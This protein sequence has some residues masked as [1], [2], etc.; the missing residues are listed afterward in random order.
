MIN[1]MDGMNGPMR[2]ME[3]LN[4]LMD[5]LALLRHLKLLPILA[6]ALRDPSLESTVSGPLAA[7]CLACSISSGG[8]HFQVNT[9]R[10]CMILLES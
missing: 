1:A 5:L 6:L 10:A 7:S 3:N 2:M 9:H 4:L 8:V